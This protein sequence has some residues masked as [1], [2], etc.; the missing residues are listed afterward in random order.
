MSS[1]GSHPEHISLHT[2]TVGTN[3]HVMDATNTVAQVKYSPPKN[4]PK[5]RK[6]SLPKQQVSPVHESCAFLPLNK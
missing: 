3:T 2:D 4:D 1:E 5:S 6:P